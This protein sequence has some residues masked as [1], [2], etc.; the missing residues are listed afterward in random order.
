MFQLFNPI[1]L[2]AS[3]AV[4]IPV[5]IHLWNKRKG[6]TL[7]VG[8][9]SLLT[10]NAKTVSR[11]IRIT[12]WPLLLLR[13][14][15]IFLVAVLLAQPFWNKIQNKN[16][17]GWIMVNDHELATVYQQQQQLIDSL[18]KRGFELRNLSPQISKITLNDTGN[19]KQSEPAI[20]NYWSYIR[21]L[22]AAL[23]AKFPIYIITNLS[24]L[25]FAGER[26]STQLDLT[27]IGINQSLK[28]DTTT[29][30]T[31]VDTDG[32]LMAMNKVSSTAGNHY[33]NIATNTPSNTNLTAAI[34]VSIYPGSNLADAKYL[35]AALAAI[36]AYT[37]RTIVINEPGST[38]PQQAIFWL[39]DS[40][41]GE[42]IMSTLI[43]GGTIFRYQFTDTSVAKNP[44]PAD[45]GSLTIEGKDQDL[46]YQYA[47]TRSKG[48]PL[49]TLADGSS[50]LSDE[51]HNGKRII[52]FNSRF[53]P[54]WTDIVWTESFARLLLPIVLPSPSSTGKDLRLM[55]A[56]QSAPRKVN[57]KQNGNTDDAGFVNKTDLSFPAWI[58]TFIIFTLERIIAHRK[59]KQKNA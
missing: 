58:A 59:S 43:N 47:S 26:P 36:G 48:N 52:Y 28:T 25:H 12:E 57:N 7:K 27:W 20:K 42:K 10:E 35:R 46:F 31:Y 39:Q 5:L 11:N 8:S 19:Y 22:D 1:A 44:L 54:Q 49:W 2:F 3:A 38:N 37:R 40:A 9:I 56:E 50:I 21:Y 32:Q 17:A 29:V 53:N 4:I 18:L 34:N 24:S 6:K 33:E 13:C 30:D 41:P 23:P 51:T 14:L 55:T 16:T 45:N 15:L